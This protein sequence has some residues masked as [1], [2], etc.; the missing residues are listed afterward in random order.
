MGDAPISP[1]GRTNHYFVIGDVEKRIGFFPKDLKTET[2]FSG[3][4]C[5]G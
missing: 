5:L 1:G 3:G 4:F 2:T